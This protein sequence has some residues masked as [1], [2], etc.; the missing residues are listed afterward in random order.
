MAKNIEP[1][2]KKIGDYLKLEEDTVFTIPE[3]QRAY[4]WG[5]DNCD[6][7]WQDINDFVE[8]ESKDRYFFGTIIIN[9]QDNDTKYGLID[10][11]QR[12]TTFLLLLKALLVRIAK[13][14]QRTKKDMRDCVLSY[15]FYYFNLNYLFHIDIK[16]LKQIF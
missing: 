5:I 10:G 16:T 1:K 12:T 6:K 14:N 15:L 7:L 3:Y 8:S 9:C 11:Q 4:S 2:L 13:G